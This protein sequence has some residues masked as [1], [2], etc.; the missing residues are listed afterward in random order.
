MAR[1]LV[2]DDDAQIRETLRIILEHAQHEV[3]EAQNGRVGINLYRKEPSDIVIVDMIMPEVD[4]VE[5]IADLRR[6][7]PGVKIIAI[8]GYSEPHLRIAKKLGALRT[9]HKPFPLTELI[10]AVQEVLS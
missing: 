3:V 1:I 8:S 9:L 6:D 2:I 4:G 5:T 10:G 7:Y